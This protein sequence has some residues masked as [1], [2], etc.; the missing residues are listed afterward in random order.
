MY[1]RWLRL[2]VFSAFGCVLSGC[3]TVPDKSV[4]FQPDALN[5][6]FEL[7]PSEDVFIPSVEAKI[8][9]DEVAIQ[10]VVRRKP[11]N[12]CDTTKGTI[13]VSILT[14]NG[15]L[16][17]EVDTAHTPR[18]IPSARQQSSRFITHLPYILPDQFIL[19]IEYVRS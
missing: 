13:S 15:D 16:F 17:D 12:C 4:S 1:H 2:L 18:N 19:R 5:V 11:G 14:P 10:G 6:Q 3:F 9:G 7:V 8:V